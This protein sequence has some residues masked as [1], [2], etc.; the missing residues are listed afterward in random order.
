MKVFIQL[1]DHDK[2]GEACDCGLCDSNGKSYGCGVYEV[3]NPEEV[4]Y[5]EYGCSEAVAIN[6]AYAKALNEG[7]EIEE[8]E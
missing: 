4:L 8:V 1:D 7:H 2:H 5:R 6:E 3:D